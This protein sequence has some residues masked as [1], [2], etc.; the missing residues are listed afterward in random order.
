MTRDRQSNH[1][2]G[3]LGE[4]LVSQWLESRG[5]I[6]LHH[7]WYTRWGEVD[8]IA[9][10]KSS[11]ALA[12]VEIKTRGRGNWDSEGILAITAH[13]QAKLCHAA[14]LFLA[15]HPDLAEFSC[16]FDVALVSYHK[17]QICSNNLTD[18]RDRA[19]VLGQPIILA[20]Y[21]MILHDYIESAFD[22]C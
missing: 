6:T 13:K 15:E 11:N 22:C 10:A 21:Q 3:R 1:K 14:A 9:Q 17:S 7:R 8:V 18:K 5:W 2:I 19:I 4:R 16:R 20:E 12:F